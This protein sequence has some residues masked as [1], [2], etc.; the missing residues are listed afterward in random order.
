MI[1][2]LEEQD[3]EIIYCEEISNEEE[4]LYKISSN[5]ESSDEELIFLMTNINS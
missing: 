1:K 4:I 5:E 3:L 2:V